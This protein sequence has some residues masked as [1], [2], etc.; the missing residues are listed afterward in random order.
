ALETLD[1]DNMVMLGGT[2]R[3]SDDVVAQAVDL[4]GAT[5]IRISGPDRYATSVAMAQQFGGWWATGRGDEYS[6]SLVCLAGSSGNGAGAVGW[7]DALVAGP[8]CGS[9]SGA[10]ANPGAPDR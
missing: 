2:A 10:A 4:T 7:P 9:A 8:W 3:L 6:G 1:V 5:P